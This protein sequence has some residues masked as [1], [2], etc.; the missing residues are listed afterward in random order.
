VPIRRD[1]PAPVV[2]VRPIP[3][4]RVWGGSGGCAARPRRRPGVSRQPVRRV[5]R[6]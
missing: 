5:Q 1:R 3:I 2:R 6:V 4:S